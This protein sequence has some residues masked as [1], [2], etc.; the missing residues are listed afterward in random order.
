MSKSHVCPI[1]P[2]DAN[3]NG[4]KYGSTHTQKEQWEQEERGL[5]SA[6]EKKEEEEGER[7]TE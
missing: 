3:E 4:I 6:K 7:G 1:N 2:P 5:G